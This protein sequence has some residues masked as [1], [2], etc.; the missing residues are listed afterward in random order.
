MKEIQKSELILEIKK[1]LKDVFV[2]EI[3]EENGVLSLEFLNGQKF[4][5][6]LE[7]IKGK[8]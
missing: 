2:A 4:S 6:W 8:L 5:L 1:A 3:T 7:N